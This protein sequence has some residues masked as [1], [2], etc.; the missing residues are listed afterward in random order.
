MDGVVVNQVVLPV[1]PLEV[2]DMNDMPPEARRIIV[3]LQHAMGASMN[4][5]HA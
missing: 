2:V 5:G 1:A 4:K 3:R